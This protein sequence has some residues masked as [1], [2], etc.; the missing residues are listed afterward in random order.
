MQTDKAKIGWRDRLAQPWPAA[1]IIALCAQLLFS[2]R[3]TTPHKLMFDETHYVPAAR[4]LVA[5]S[6]PLNIEH[7]LVGKELIALGMLLFGDNSLGWRALAT[8]A[9]AATVMGL[10]AI[11][12]LL[13]GRLR[14]SIV[15]AVLAMLNFTLFIQARIAMLDIFEMAFLTLGLAAMLWS[16]VAP[17]EK[18]LRRWIGG[19]ALMGF[20]IGS[21]WA[22][23]PYLGLVAATFLIV[24]WRD[25]RRAG[26][27]P[28]RAFDTSDGSLWQEL[29]A[30]SALAWLLGVSVAV[31]LTTFLPAF[32]YAQ[33]P[34]TLSSLLPFQ[35]RMYAEQTQVLAPHPY[36]SQWWTWPLDIRPIWY[37]YEP[38][39]GGVYRGVLMIGNPVIWW[40][41]LL[42]A[43]N[44]VWRWA[45]GGPAKA[46]IPVGLW[47]G[48]FLPFALI[49][50]SLGFMYYYAPSS[51]FLCGVIAVALSPPRSTRRGFWQRDTLFIAASAA[52]FL[53]FYP[54]IAATVLP[55][56]G[57][58]QQ[59]MWLSTW[60]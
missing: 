55:Q 33:D 37:L 40:G 6:H 30:T 25:A 15:G 35:A 28:V 42:A 10:F 53:Y 11:L 45:M 5:L 44:L 41:G 51:V 52:M 13:F 47:L 48:G 38:S 58:F 57:A 9:G 56:A 31:Y 1:L 19:A 22:A 7:P 59:W 46:L 50:K 39:D 12:Q 14:T 34:L 20:A 23:V 8:I 24:R 4:A 36:Q 2:W 18:V 27:A 32:L 54:I 60:P 29:S 16:M 49:P 21:K 26:L 17:Q 3:L 43:L